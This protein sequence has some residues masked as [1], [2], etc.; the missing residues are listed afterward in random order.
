MPPTYTHFIPVKPNPQIF[1]QMVT[2][3]YVML[4]VAAVAAI[5]VAFYMT[6]V[7]ADDSDDDDGGD[8]GEHICCISKQFLFNLIP[9]L[10]IQITSTARFSPVFR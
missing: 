2:V 10:I 4:F 5:C 8:D 6:S 7:G 9:I 3:T 1:L